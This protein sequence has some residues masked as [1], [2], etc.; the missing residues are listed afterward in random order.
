MAGDEGSMYMIIT[1]VGWRQSTA[2]STMSSYE[3]AYS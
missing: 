2:M 3:Q 1:Q